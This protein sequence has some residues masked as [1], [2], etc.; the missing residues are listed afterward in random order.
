[1]L[2]AKGPGPASSYNQILAGYEADGTPIPALVPAF[3]LN[4]YGTRLGGGD[5]FG[6]EVH[7]ILAMPGPGPT[8]P[9][10]VRGFHAS[11]VPIATVDYFAYGVLA[12]GGNVSAADVDDVSFSEILTGPGPGPAFGPQVR[13]WSYDGSSQP[14]GLTKV[15]YY[16][17]GT[18]NYGVSADALDAD[19]DGYAEILTGAGP[20]PVFGPHVRGWNYD[21]TVLASMPG[22]SFLAYSTLK[23]GVNAVGGELDGDARGEILTGPGPGSVFG[24]HLRGFQY[25]GTVSAIGNISAFVFGTRYGL[26]VAAAD[27]EAGWLLRD[28]RRA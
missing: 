9:P 14:Q 4:G 6:D 23:Y 12:Y 1:M 8:H 25:A 16:A 28:R 19:A 27:V 18:L 10:A 22:L 7:E 15:N 20:G 21:G 5:L 24:A 17:Y 26:D 3:S 2:A 13:G 11:G